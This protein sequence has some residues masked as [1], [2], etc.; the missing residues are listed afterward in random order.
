[1]SRPAILDVTRE[2][3]GVQGSPRGGVGAQSS[4]GLGGTAGLNGELASPG[5]M[6]TRQMGASF[7][8]A[9]QQVRAR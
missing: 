2:E 9:N 6:S 1:M 3:T 4:A 5:G 7:S 8:A